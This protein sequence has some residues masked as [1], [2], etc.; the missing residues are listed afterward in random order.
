MHHFA[1]SKS[2]DVLDDGK[3]VV[4]FVYVWYRALVYLSFMCVFDICVFACLSICEFAIWKTF[5]VKGLLVRCR[6]GYVCVYGAALKFI[7]K[8]RIKPK[9][10]K[11]WEFAKEK[12]ETA[13]C[14]HH[15]NSFI[16]CS[17]FSI[18]AFIGQIGMKRWWQQW[19]WWQR[20]W[21]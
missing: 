16:L 5:D 17:I 10:S 21:R 20:W 12:G 19:R 13:F 4:F 14:T 3:E 15:I 18:N 2:V 6:G 9:L 11:L 8:L 7:R 1:I